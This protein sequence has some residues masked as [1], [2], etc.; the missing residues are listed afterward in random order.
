MT[1]KAVLKTRNRVFPSFNVVWD[2]PGSLL[3]DATAWAS[4]IDGV[5]NCRH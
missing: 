1:E 2:A 5:G 3:E 4:R